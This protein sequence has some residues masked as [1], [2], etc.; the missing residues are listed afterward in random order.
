[1]RHA[2]HIDTIPFRLRAIPKA[3]LYIHEKVREAEYAPREW[4]KNRRL[5]MSMFAI[6]SKANVHSSAVIR[7]MIVRRISCAFALVATRG[8]DCTTDKKGELVMTFRKSD[9][10]DHWISQG[11]YPV[12]IE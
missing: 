4:P 3:C 8:A 12:V 9:I 1:M 5:N 10:G 6:N 7:R 11:M 2:P